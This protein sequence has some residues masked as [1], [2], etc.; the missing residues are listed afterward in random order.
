LKIKNCEKWVVHIY[1]LKL[2]GC[3]QYFSYALKNFKYSNLG[4]ILQVAAF[5]RKFIAALDHKNFE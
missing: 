4:S 2:L 5:P 3:N 1:Y